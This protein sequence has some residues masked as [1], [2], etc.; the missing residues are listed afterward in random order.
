MSVR[1][2]G[3]PEVR[4]QTCLWPE[5]LYSWGADDVYARGATGRCLLL[6]FP[7][8]A[9]RGQ[10]LARRQQGAAVALPEGLNESAPYFGQ[11]EERHEPS[12]EFRLNR[13]VFAV[14]R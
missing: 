7:S 4:H 6:A 3:R 14:E 12:S 8:M 9:I 5:D 10:G 2:P 13:Y 11:I 1:S